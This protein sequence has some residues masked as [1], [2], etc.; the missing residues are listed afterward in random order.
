MKTTPTPRARATFWPALRA[1]ST[2][3]CVPPCFP[4]VRLRIPP[5]CGL[6]VS[7]SDRRLAGKLS[8]QIQA[9]ESTLGWPRHS[10]RRLA[11]PR[12]HVRGLPLGRARHNLSTRRSNILGAR[13]WRAPKPNSAPDARWPGARYYSRPKWMLSDWTPRNTRFV[14]VCGQDRGL[15]ALAAQV[16]RPS[17]A[18]GPTAWLVSFVRSGG[19]GLSGEP[20]QADEI[21]G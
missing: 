21:V 20:C 4:G 12:C 8:P 17:M 9:P 18:R 15:M 16:H 6:T 5:M 7:R 11:Y 19:C 10:G 3:S 2:T 13:A 14:R 1:L